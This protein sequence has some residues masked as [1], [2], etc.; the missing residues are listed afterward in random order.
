M[1]KITRFLS[2][3]CAVAVLAGISGA[4]VLSARAS[5]DNGQPA[6]TTAETAAETTEAPVKP[7]PTEFAHIYECAISGDQIVIDG[8]MEGSFSD[9]AYYDNYLYLFEQKPYQRDLKGRTDYAAWITKGDALHF[10]IPLN[11]GTQSD[12]LY[13]SFVVAVYDGEEY[14]QVSNEVY[15]TNPEV[16]AKYTEPYKTGQTKKGLL[17]QT[18]QTM[19]ADA[20]ELGVNH[21]I[22]NIPFS[23]ILGSGI[24][25]TYDGRTYHFSSD[26]LAVYDDTI[27][28]M[29][30]KNM[31]VTAVLLNDWNNATPQLYYPGVTRQPAGT[32]NYYGFHVAT[33]EGFETLKAIAAFLTER[34]S[35]LQSPYGRVSNWVI[36]NEINNQLWN[37]MGPMDLT[38]YVKTYEKAFRVCYTAIKSTNANDRVYLS[39][40]YNWMNEMDGQLKYGGK[41]IIDS[42]N[43]IANNQGQMEWGLAYHPYP[44][45]LID[46]VFW[47]DAQATGLVKND[48]NSPVINFA[49]L[50]VLTD[51]FCQ[52]ALKTPSGHVRH[53]IL[54]E[55]GFTAYSPTRGDVPE[56]QAA[57]FAYSYYL[58][59]S[60]P[61][62]D[63]YTLS[64]QVDAPSE[65]KD[66]LKLGLWECDMSKPNLIEATKRRKIWQVFRDIDKK[67]STLE[68]SEF[69]KSLIGINK[70]S[71][72]VPNFKWKNL[73][74]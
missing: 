15:V 68:A 33:E 65:A 49:N 59:D 72:V 73:E 34:Y 18:T 67:N 5:T 1:N 11:H 20:F 3:C 37:Y 62:I 17:I 71:D 61:Y 42:F 26:V 57:A 32:A 43:S 30:E 48:F 35:S 25:Y 36:G 44:C 41:E 27:R 47:D 24:D 6:E 2:L 69:A 52:E 56:L 28:R 38:N 10:S 4:G 60:N 29:S 50:N 8:Q 53:I 64:R 40:S 19:I 23:H 66:G 46:P 54:T 21:V 16:M 7:A 63:A 58:V 45:P 31:T 13:S 14:I 9:S 22:V 74:K 39:L 70:W 51:Y 55:Q 12:R